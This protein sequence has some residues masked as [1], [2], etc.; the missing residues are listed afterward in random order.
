MKFAAREAMN[1][2][3]GTIVMDGE[4]MAAVISFEATWEFEK[5]DINVAGQFGTDTKYV[6]GAGKGTVKLYKIDSRFQTK[7]A[8]IVRTGKEVSSNIISTLS[9]PDG[10][11]T[12]RVVLKNCKFDSIVLANWEAKKPSEVE[13]P[14]T[15]SDFEYLDVV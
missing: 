15:F 7:A 8:S 11:G 12:E 1:G 10:R 14:F 3:W 2:T 6:G 5:E 4:T 13:L 9:D